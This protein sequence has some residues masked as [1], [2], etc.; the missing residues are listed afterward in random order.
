MFVCET[1]LESF[2][3]LDLVEELLGWVVERLVA[4]LSGF[5]EGTDVEEEA[6]VELS[7]F[8]LLPLVLPFFFVLFLSLFLFPLLPTTPGERERE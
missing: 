1:P 7:L 3:E 2:V 8:C 6:L 5:S 4:D